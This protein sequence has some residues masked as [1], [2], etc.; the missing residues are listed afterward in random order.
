M[1][2][3]PSF[4]GKTIRQYRVMEEIGGGGMG[5]VYKAED[6]K[7]R[8][9][10]ALKFLPADVATDPQA[11]ERFQREAQSASSLNHPGICT[12]YDIDTQDGHP[13]IDMEL[14]KG[15]TLKQLLSLVA[16]DIKRLLDIGAQ[17]A[18]ALDAAHT[19][20]IVH[21]DIKP[22]NIFV[23]ERGQAKI[24][25]FGLAKNVARNTSEKTPVASQAT[26]I[27]DP[28]LTSPGTAV[29]TVSYMSPEQTLGKELDARTDIF[30]FGIVLYEMSTGRM[31]FAGNTSAAIFDAI[32]HRAPVAPVRLNPDIPEELERIINKAIEKDRDLR[33]QHAS[34][35]RAD[36]KRLKRD[37]DSSRSA[38]TPIEE[39]EDIG[40]TATQVSVPAAATPRRGT[41]AS[42]RARV[43]STSTQRA[44]A[45]AKSP[46][47]FTQ[48]DAAS[49]ASP[50]AG[51]NWAR[52]GGIAGVILAAIAGGGYFYTHRAQALTMKGSIVVSDFAN[53]TGDS[54]FDR[55]LQQGLTVQ[56]EQSTFLNILPDQ[57]VAEQ[58]RLMGQPA[59]TKLTSDLARQV[60]V[61]TGSSAT[62]EGSITQVGN[63]YDLIVKAVNCSTG[64]TLTS[65][66]TDA[67]DKDHVLPALSKL[68]SDIRGKLGESL[69]S[70]QQHSAALEQAT[71]TSLEALKSY[72]MGRETLVKKGD[73]EAAIPFFQRAISLDSN[74]A[75]AYAS[76]GT[77]FS[78]LGKSGD[79]KENMRKAN[80][81]RDRVSDREKFYI[82][83][84]FDQFVTGDL[85][86]TVQ[87]YELWLQTYPADGGL[88]DVNL[89]NIYLQI[90]FLDKALTACKE[91]DRLD[92][93]GKLATGNFITL[94]LRIGKIDEARALV[95][96]AFGSDK[97]S[98]QY[99]GLM[100]QVAGAARDVTAMQKEAAW[101][102]SKPAFAS[103]VVN[104]DRAMAF[105]KGQF[106]K[107]RE[108]MLQQINA[109]DPAKNKEGR[110][111]LQANLAVLD[112]LLGYDSQALQD[113]RAALATAPNSDNAQAAAAIIFGFLGDTQHQ[114][115][116][117][118]DLAKRFPEDTSFQQVLL[119]SA[120]AASAYFHKDYQK[121]LEILQPLVQ[122]EMGSIDGM[123]STYLR[124]LI[125][126]RFEKPAEAAAEFQRII[127]HPGIIG[128]SPTER[129]SHLGLARAKAMLGDKAGAR[130]AY[131]DVF[132]IWKDADPDLP[133]FV[134][135]KAEYVKLQ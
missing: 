36:L 72:T 51:I 15:Q 95:E 34:E 67:A 33:Y 117:M 11:L 42:G 107:G 96:K 105:S 82:T 7:L 118:D 71:T 63:Q 1:P 20:G 77:V 128:A 111:N 59:M 52:W 23:T 104:I 126:L 114:Q 40:D 93:G 12:I 64:E 58:L 70:I 98:P 131:Q 90:G 112:M 8:R 19:E 79:A 78:N 115:T 25:D 54:V 3:Q 94:Y 109:V 61:R 22:A 35:I 124:G 10:V 13:F 102:A 80:D 6:T 134:A 86:K 65:V 122:Y 39:S 4:V 130:T 84:H 106:K 92:P 81:L 18:D 14:L 91:A 116:I 76:L 75:M 87:V 27:D 103:A 5:V 37:T 26:I 48:D 43:A 45:A 83:S 31:A 24:L 119:P 60:C 30:S 69:G 2:E 21:R 53:T 55:T 132:A 89:C 101:F 29:G 17:I 113:I 133:P 9:F 121:A 44:A 50:R 47:V 56:L 62:L 85:I 16:L 88:V 49:A 74:F 32:L 38:I 41:P 99:H 125:Y 57:R 28:N 129:L 100:M 127:D 135:A 120:R 110:A 68:A 123:D 66:S 46:D 97:D 108:V 73:S